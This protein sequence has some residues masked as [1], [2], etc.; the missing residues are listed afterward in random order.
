MCVVSDGRQLQD[1]DMKTLVE[2]HW[3]GRLCELSLRKHSLT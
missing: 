2:D 1:P 3:P